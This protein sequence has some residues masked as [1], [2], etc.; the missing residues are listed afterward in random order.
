MHH[1]A[2]KN[3][4]QV[5]F[6]SL[7]QLVEKDNVV[8]FIDAFVDKLELTKLGF[9]LNQIKNEGRPSYNSAFF[10]KLYIYG[11]LNG[12]RTSRKLEKECLRNTEL[13]WLMSGLKPNYHS[14]S[15]FRKD[16]PEAL[17]NTFKLFVSFLKDA[18]LLSGTTIA[19]D[20]TKIRAH[21][22][23]KNN[24]NQKK[25]ERHYAYIEEKTNQ[26]LKELD[27]AD[28]QKQ[29]E[30]VKNIE[31]KLANLKTRQIKYEL[32]EAALHKSGEPQIS[33]TDPDSRALLI[34]G[35]VVEVSYN[36]QAAIDDKHKLVAGT[37]TIN[38][39]DRNALSAI[40]LETKE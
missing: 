27:E 15:D 5:E 2:H 19:I 21:N 11:Y 34:Q 18:D 14:I 40:A 36:T 7:E 29:P 22:S 3:R 1:I 20:G 26:Y 38:R 35:Q 12:I 25:I 33:T 8:R 4:S 13:Q 9:R 23:K 10:M 28:K 32:L 16:N 24:Y 17:R 39:N 31:E 37:H 6:I 30:K